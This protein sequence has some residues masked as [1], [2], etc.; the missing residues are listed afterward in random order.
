MAVG[1]GSSLKGSESRPLKGRRQVRVQ[2]PSL[3]FLNSLVKGFTGMLERFGE[4]WDV[5]PEYEVLVCTTNLKLNRKDELIMGGGIARAFKARFPHLPA[6][7]GLQRKMLDVHGVERFLFFDTSLS[8]DNQH[9]VGLPTKYDW[10]EDS[11]IDLIDTGLEALRKFADIFKVKKV[12]MTRPG[13]GLGNLDWNGQV[14]DLVSHWLDDRFT[15][16]NKE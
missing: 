16:V 4:F 14:R 1:Q 2:I 3:A 7:W 12:L 9:L 11:D 8:A 13:C 6:L 15:V 5:A 10:T